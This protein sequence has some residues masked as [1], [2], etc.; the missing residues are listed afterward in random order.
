MKRKRTKITQQLIDRVIQLY[1]SEEKPTARN[2]GR[3]LDINGGTVISILI[4]N[5]IEIRQKKTPKHIEEQIIDFYVNKKMFPKDIGE[6]L[7]MGFETVKSVL[8]REDVQMNSVG[9][10]KT[11]ETEQQVITMHIGEKLFPHKIGKLLKI[12]SKTVVA[13]LKRNDVPINP[14]EKPK[15]IKMLVCDLYNSGLGFQDIEERAGVSSTFITKTLNENSI[16]IRNQHV[17]FSKEDVD[18]V[19]KMYF[20]DIKKIPQISKEMKCS[21]YYVSKILK[22]NNITIRKRVSY[23]GQESKVV[24]MYV[25]KILSVPKISKEL[26]IPTSTIYRMLSKNNIKKRTTSQSV[27]KLTNEEYDRYLL[28]LPA[29]VK[30]KKKVIALTLKQSIKLLPNYE[31]RGLGGVAGAYHLDHKY[32]ILEGFKNDVPEETIANINNLEFIPW[33]KNR[34]KGKNCSIT[35]GELYLKI[36]SNKTTN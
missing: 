17:E 15:E 16:K 36:N 30:Y 9:N 33:E 25:N 22:E 19:I 21:I 10:K 27:L 35:L 31:K 20:I 8:R 18:K 1:N 3:I 26:N 5:E 14:Y 32:S 24:Y 29:Q 2:V 11:K 4:K 13:I 7:D 28:S 23:Y 6:M 12:S 34:E